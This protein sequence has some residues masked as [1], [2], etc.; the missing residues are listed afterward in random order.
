MRH[1]TLVSCSKFC[2]Q[3]SLLLFLLPCTQ[4]LNM[5]VLNYL[6]ALALLAFF[7]ACD[8]AAEQG[9]KT[10]NLKSTTTDTPKTL[11]LVQPPSVAPAS[12][13]TVAL[14]PAHG[15]PGHRCDISVGAPLNSKP[16]AVAPTNNQTQQIQSMINPTPA[17][18]PVS[19]GTG[20]KNPA[21]GMP[22]HRC[23]I[24]VG[25]PLN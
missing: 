24:A 16:N 18:A 14:N 21:H 3:L 15:Q 5:K 13:G 1:T 2:N 19:T 25:A 6:S 20:A 12:T 7:S 22:G 23:D 10:N 11:Q 9:Y 17:P 8:N 4:I